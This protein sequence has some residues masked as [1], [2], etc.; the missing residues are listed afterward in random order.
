MTHT[1]PDGSTME[2]GYGS[3]RPPGY[4]GQQVASTYPWVRRNGGVW[5]KPEG[6]RSSH[7]IREVILTA[8]TAAE[9][10]ECLFWENQN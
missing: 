9:A 3:D 6:H 8:E 2:L 10:M 4:V 1:Y 5:R 7:K